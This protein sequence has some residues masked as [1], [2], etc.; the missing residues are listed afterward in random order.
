LPCS[1]RRGILTP[2]FSQ[3]F[4]AGRDKTGWG[5]HVGIRSP[6][7]LLFACVLFTAGLW[8]ALSSAQQS[9]EPVR[10]AFLVGNLKYNDSY[11]VRLERTVNDAKDLAKDLEDV[12]FDKKNIKVATDIKNK[13]AFNKEFEAFLKTVNP[14]DFVLFYFSGHG[15]GVETL[16]RNYLLFTDVKSPFTYTRGK[17]SDDERRNADLVRVRIPRY[18]PAYQ[19]EEIPEG[20]S[21]IS[22]AEIEAKIAEKD[23]GNVLMI[24]D[25]CRS[26]ARTALDQVEEQRVTVRRSSESGSRLITEAVPRD[27]FMVL[28]AAQFGEQAI[29]GFSEVGRNSLFTEILRT[30]LPRPGQTIRGLANRVKLIVRQSALAQGKQQE[31]EFAVPRGATYPDTIQL[32]PSIGAQDYPMAG[33]NCDGSQANWERIKFSGNRDSLDRHLKRFAGCPSA[34]EAAQ[35][36]IRLALM[37]DDKPEE[38]AC[39]IADA[40]WKQIGDLADAK[41][42]DGAPDP[43]KLIDV[44]RDLPDNERGEF[45]KLLERLKFPSLPDVQ[46]SLVYRLN[47]HTE[48]FLGCKTVEVAHK[49]IARIKKGEPK[50]EKSTAGVTLDKISL[51]DEL[52][53]SDTDMASTRPPEVPGVPF[54]KLKTQAEEAIKACEA[55]FKKNERVARFLFNR[56]RA[57]Y[58]LALRAKPAPDAG[59][60]KESFELAAKYYKAASAAGYVSALN[61]LAVL[62]EAGDVA[63]KDD[64]EDPIKLFSRGAEQGHPLA[65][66]NLAIHYRNGPDNDGRG[67]KRD[68]VAAAEWFSKAADAGYVSAM[69]EL[70]LALVKGEGASNPRRGMEWLLTAANQGATRAKFLLGFYYYWGADDRVKG[71]NSIKPDYTLSLLWFGRLAE[72]RDRLALR[73]LAEHLQDGDGLSSPQPEIAERY[74]R[75]AAYAGDPYAQVV[76]ADRLRRGFALAKPQFGSNEALDLLERAVVQGEASAALGLAHIYRGGDQTAGGRPQQKNVRKA[77]EY[78]FR[79]IDLAVLSDRDVE[80]NGERLPEIGAAHLLIEMVR[81]PQHPEQRKLLKADEIERLERYYGATDEQGKVKIRRLEVVLTCHVGEREWSRREKKWVWPVTWPKRKTLWVWDWGRAESP[82]EFQFRALERADRPCTDN[83]LLRRTLVDIFNQ[84]KKSGE[85]FTA[86]VEQKI[87][88]AKGENNPPKKKKERRGRGRRYG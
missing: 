83:D 51:C 8:P 31:P 32:V 60:R 30:E 48:R 17:M 81:D 65:M 55:D 61:D 2:Y 21:A 14:G 87:K 29:E 5:S 47:R 39:D 78:A 76:F 45:L 20:G 66:Y 41:D 73:W 22:T 24:L 34:P 35:E 16:R 63:Q 25:A 67:A 26:L 37:S 74:W 3:K 50:D 88:T 33:G 19:T 28:Y 12:G 54:D 9:D 70:G 71:I 23:P 11:I 7:K 77:M 4:R 53:A 15:F 46:K 36:Y 59:L 58:A 27:R 84:A 56:A 72:V 42:K 18:I 10:R 69:V 80:T 13:A 38:T 82:T 86:L 85:S 79:A 57:H 49:E 43:S 64:D 52:A 40:D 6:L 62:Y 1:L 44:W 75:L 68:L